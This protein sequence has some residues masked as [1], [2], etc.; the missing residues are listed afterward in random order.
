MEEEIIAGIADRLNELIGKTVKDTLESSI[1]KEIQKVLNK[2]LTD[3]EFYQTMANEVQNG[4]NQLMSEIQN[5]KEEMEIGPEQESHSPG[6]I[7]SYAADK[8]K[9]IYSKTEDA[10]FSVIDIVEEQI[11]LISQV[12]HKTGCVDSKDLAP[13]L[14]TMND[15]MFK[16]LT[17][18]SFQ[19]IIGQQIEKVILFIKNIEEMIN[20][21]YISQ[22]MMLESKKENPNLCSEKIKKNA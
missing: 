15:N 18:L 17:A 21:L 20:R 4:L 14:E 22:N 11:S 6:Y 2:A 8:L 1:E 7:F 9:E 19:D 3:G 16:I 5:L 13:I 12:K 10:T